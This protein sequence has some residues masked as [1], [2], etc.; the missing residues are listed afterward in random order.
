LAGALD[1]NSHD[2]AEEIKGHMWASSDGKYMKSLDIA[3]PGFLNITLTNEAILSNI[4]ILNQAISS[5]FDFTKEQ[6]I[7]IEFISANPTGAL[8]IGHG[9]GAF[10]GDVLSNILSYAGA[11]VIREFYI[12]DSR[13]SNQIKELG[14][15]ALG[16]GEQYK[17]PQIE[18]M[19][20]DMDFS[21]FEAG[22][23]G[24]IL[25][26]KVQEYNK[27]FIENKLGI[28]FDEWY[29]EDENIRATGVADSMLEELK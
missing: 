2:I 27:N 15:T 25:G 5:G 8:H 12:N 22:D 23:V 21:G 26:E 6:K 28:K 18:R 16:V 24:F 9:R 20:E 1:R 14:K 13:E 4:G 29:S 3:G 10:Y 19:I 17:T 7:N 11:N